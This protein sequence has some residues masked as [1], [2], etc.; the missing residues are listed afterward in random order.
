MKVEILKATEADAIALRKAQLKRAE[1]QLEVEVVG[2]GEAA[3][4]AAGEVVAWPGMHRGQA[5]E[6]QLVA[7]AAWRQ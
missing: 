2:E 4:E 1:A 7:A 3:H 6:A 5:A